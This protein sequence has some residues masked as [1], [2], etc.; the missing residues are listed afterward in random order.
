MKDVLKLGKVL[1]KAEQKQ[2]NGGF[3]GDFPA[4]CFTGGGP[5]EGGCGPHQICCFVPNV[6]NRC[7]LGTT[8]S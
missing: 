4:K 5:G 2:V 7:V 3:F 6:G 1:T 8:C